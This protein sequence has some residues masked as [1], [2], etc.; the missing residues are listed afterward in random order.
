MHRIQKLKRFLTTKT[1]RLS[2]LCEHCPAQSMSSGCWRCW[3]FNVQPS[4]QPGSGPI[5]I[6]H[7]MTRGKWEDDQ[8]CLSVPPVLSVILPASWPG[9]PDAD[10]DSAL[11]QFGIGSGKG[12]QACAEWRG[13]EEH[14]DQ[15][16]TQQNCGLFVRTL[17]ALP[18]LPFARCCQQAPG[19]PGPCLLLWPRQS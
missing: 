3:W 15:K 18:F 1:T 14:E 10:W 13:G 9:F 12:H 5:Y 6:C 4:C 7:N 16:E 17:R 8:E 11:G 19:S 2:A